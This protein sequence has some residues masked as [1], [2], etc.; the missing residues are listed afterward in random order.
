MK[1]PH[2]YSFLVDFAWFWGQKIAIF[3][4]LTLFQK[5]KDF[6]E[7]I[8]FSFQTKKKKR[9]TTWTLRILIFSG[10]YFLRNT[11]YGITELRNTELRNLEWAGLVAA[12]SEPAW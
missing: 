2:F 1:N 7:K 8:D 10:G 11:E 3:Q 5:I 6:F 12:S 4:F 9:R